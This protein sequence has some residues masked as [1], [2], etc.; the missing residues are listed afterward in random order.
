[1]KILTLKKQLINASNNGYIFEAQ[2]VV[3]YYAWARLMCIV[4]SYASALLLQLLHGDFLCPEVWQPLNVIV[5][6]ALSLHVIFLEIYEKYNVGRSIFGVLI[7]FDIISL[8][9]FVMKV[10]AFHSGFLFLLLSMVVI[11]AVAGGLCQGLKYAFWAAGLLNIAFSVSHYFDLNLI[12]PMVALNNISLLVVAGLGGY[13]GEQ[14]FSASE[15]FAAQRDEIETLTNIN[16]VIIDNIPSGLIVV[17]A[18]YKITFANRG[19]AKIFG[20]LALEGK[21][22]KDFF[23]DLETTLAELPIASVNSKIKTAVR[24][25]MNYYNYKKEKLILEIII[26]KIPYGNEKS[27]YLCLLQNV[28]EIKNL[29]FSMRQKEKL[30]AVG[31]LAAGIAHEI[32]NPLASISGSVQLLQGQLQTQSVEDKK[33][34]SIMVKE[35]DRLNGLVTEFLDYVRPDVRS[36]DPVHINLLIKE[37]I[38]LAKLN[39]NLS[40]K[41]EHRSD[42]RAHGVILGHY[43][44]LKQAFMNIVIN[45]YQAMV[46]NLRPELFIQSYDSEGKV[47]LLIQDN[48]VGM[49][50][51]TQKRIFEPFHTTKPKGTGLGLAITHKILESHEAEI[52]VESEIGKGSKFTILFPTDETRNDNKQVLRRQA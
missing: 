1:M 9:Y 24:T 23:V 22:L 8:I 30:A 32:R 12:L 40:R 47:V 18:N 46:D 50:A 36:E 48:G 39:Q 44:K 20:D 43:D 26:S 19:S 31:Q 25:E 37:V 28:T 17:D 52:F 51:E 3:K 35:I 33:L 13:V 49:T 6:I 34:F 42:L 16:E 11:G 10:G 14:L 15:N 29:E 27:N 38:E 4:V 45:S 41:V 21:Y 5:A 7:G 2:N